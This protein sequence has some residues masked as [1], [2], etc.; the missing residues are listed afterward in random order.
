MLY[1]DCVM[2]YEPPDSPYR[3]AA[4]QMVAAH[5]L[6]M[7]QRFRE[8]L[9]IL[10]TAIVIAPSYPLAY[11]LR[12]IVF[13]NLGLAAQADADRARERQLAAIEGYPVADVVDGVA[14][15]TM[16]RVRSGGVSQREPR[17]GGS[18]IARVLTPAVLG[19]LM[20][21]GIGAVGLGGVLLVTDALENGDGNTVL[22]PNG[23]AM[24]TVAGSTETPSP[25]DEPTPDSSADIVGSP[26]S[27]SSATG[28]WQDAGFIVTNGGTAD[29]F[30]GF[31]QDPV[32]ITL[33]GGGDFA[34]F[35]YEDSA[36]ASRDWIISGASVPDPQPG[37]SAPI[38]ESVWF[39]ANM[40]VVVFSSVG[41]AFEAFVDM[42]P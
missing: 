21:I 29:G 8:A 2:Q 18:G 10:N 1:A 16:R 41:G 36:A 12:A 20:L 7:K 25:T 13:D 42:V 17:A 33:S 32:S 40:I 39:N 31:E 35:V 11:A 6:I 22:N 9:D 5:E 26:Y 23:E 28:A 15:I 3:R 30:D 34:V 4:D 37:R 19:I 14:T 24:P 38:S 27:L